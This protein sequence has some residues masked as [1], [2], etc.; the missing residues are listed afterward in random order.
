MVLCTSRRSAF[1]SAFSAEASKAGA[2]P[3]SVCSRTSFH[4]RRRKRFAP[5]TPDSCHSN[6]MSAGEANIMNRR[7]VSA[8]YLS[9]I[10]CGSIPLFFDLDILIMPECST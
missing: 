1:W 5:S 2:W 7:T 8:P 9:T 6:V 3:S 10:S 4:T